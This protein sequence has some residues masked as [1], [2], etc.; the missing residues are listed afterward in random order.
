MST[1]HL[2]PADIRELYD[3][4]EWRNAAGVLSTACPGE[5]ADIDVLRAFRLRRRYL[6]VPGGNRG[7]IAI[8]SMAG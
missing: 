3:V 8:A 1:L 5:W 6:T 2:V 4:H 7:P